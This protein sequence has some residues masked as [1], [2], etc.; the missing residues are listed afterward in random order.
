MNNLCKYIGKIKLPNNM[1]QIGHTPTFDL[2]K[3]ED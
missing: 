1:P 3:N 2:L